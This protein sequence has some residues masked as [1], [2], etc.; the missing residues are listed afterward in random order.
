MSKLPI[1]SNEKII[2]SKENLKK[3]TKKI[4]SLRI[5]FETTKKYQRKKIDSP[6]LKKKKF[7]LRENL[8]N[9]AEKISSSHNLKNKVHLIRNMFEKSD[10]IDDILPQNGRNSDLKSASSQIPNP[11]QSSSKDIQLDRKVSKKMDFN[12]QQNIK[13]YFFKENVLEP[14]QK[15]S[16]GQRNSDFMDLSNRKKV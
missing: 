8:P 14:K 11:G 7:K 3:E 10:Q 15:S 6:I 13:N 16:I 4:E 2:E 9:S 1:V 12:K 5:P